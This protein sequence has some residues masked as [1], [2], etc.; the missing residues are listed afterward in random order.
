MEHRFNDCK[1]QLQ[2]GSQGG[3]SPQLKELIALKQELEQG[4]L[5]PVSQETTEL[6]ATF[7]TLKDCL[8]TG[9]MVGLT[10]EESTDYY[11]HYNSQGWRKGN[12]LPIINLQSSMYQWRRSGQKEI[13]SQT[14]T[15]AEYDRLVADGEINRE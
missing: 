10:L 1:G 9:P 7:F 13:D 14:D 4:S 6:A 12:G 11:H 15:K 2:A 5:L 8:D 3:Y